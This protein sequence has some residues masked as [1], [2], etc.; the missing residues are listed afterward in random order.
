[1]FLLCTPTLGGA[2]RVGD[3][4]DMARFLC[5]DAARGDVRSTTGASGRLSGST[6]DWHVVLGRLLFKSSGDSARLPGDS[7]VSLNP[8]DP[9]LPGVRALVT[10]F[11]LSWSLPVAAA[12]ASGRTGGGDDTDGDDAGS[13]S[14]NASRSSV[15]V[16]L[17]TSMGRLAIEP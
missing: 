11:E 9:S 6:F 12:I 14:L 1:M 2:T 7:G 13:V 3:S 10:T 16:S 4:S 5:S 15:W 8:N 17:L